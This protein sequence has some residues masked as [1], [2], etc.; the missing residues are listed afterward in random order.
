MAHDLYIVTAATA[1]RR[2]VLSVRKNY[3]QT[4][5][6]VTSTSYDSPTNVYISMGIISCTQLKHIANMGQH[7]QAWKEKD[8]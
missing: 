3:K 6:H 2:G 1:S 7:R 4:D 5:S 8:D